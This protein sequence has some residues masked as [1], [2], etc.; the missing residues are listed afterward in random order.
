VGVV[1]PHILSEDEATYAAY[2]QLMGEKGADLVL[3]TVLELTPAL[4]AQTL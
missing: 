4:I 1:P 2:K 3:D